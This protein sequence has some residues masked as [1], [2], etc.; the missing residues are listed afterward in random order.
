MN[1]NH[2][3][4][5]TFLI[6]SNGFLLG[7]GQN[8][9]SLALPIILC[10][11]WPLSSS[12]PFMLLFP[13]SKGSVQFSHIGLFFSLTKKLQTTQVLSSFIFTNAIHWSLAHSSP[14]S[15]LTNVNSYKSG[16]LSCHTHSLYVFFLAIKTILIYL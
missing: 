3:L 15:C 8:L 2:N 6:S 13:F 16:P 12:H 14:Y 5:L 7:F 9:Q 11:V 4:P 1:A 10:L